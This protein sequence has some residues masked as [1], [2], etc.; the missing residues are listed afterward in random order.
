MRA[1][2]GEEAALDRAL[3]VL[4]DLTTSYVVVGRKDL[5]G[6]SQL[7]TQ[8]STRLDHSGCIITVRPVRKKA[9]VAQGYYWSGQP[10][11]YSNGIPRP[12]HIYILRMLS[13]ASVPMN[14]YI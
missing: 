2:F 3:A 10:T 12:L 1:V 4:V 13:A 8:A 14:L 7:Q 6:D 5:V 9:R 11:L